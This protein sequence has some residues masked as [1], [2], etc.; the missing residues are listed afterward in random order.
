VEAGAE[1][2]VGLLAL[3]PGPDIGV[4]GAAV[5][6]NLSQARAAAVLAGSVEAGLV[7]VRDGRY[8][9]PGPGQVV[10]DAVRRR[11]LGRLFGWYRDLANAADRVLRPAE[12]PNFASRQPK[13]AFPDQ[14]AALGWLDAEAAN[15][16][17]AVRAAA[18]EHPVLSWQIAAAMYGWLTRREQRAE[19]I[20]LYT[21]AAG[22]AARCGD[23]AGEA[24]ITGRLGIAYGLLG[25]ATEAIAAFHRA[26]EI[27][28]AG[29][30]LLGAATGLLNIGAMQVATG[31]P[32]D[33]IASLSRA[34][35]LGGGLP[36]TTHFQALVHSNLA[37]A[38]HIA[39][40]YA[41]A[42]HHYETALRHSEAGCAD[43]DIAQV[44]LGLA[45]LCSTLG[46]DDRA[47]AYAHRGLRLADRADDDLMRAQSHEALGRIA[48][49]TGGTRSARVHLRAALS[50]YTT[51]GYL[52]AGAVREQLAGLEAV[53]TESAAGAPAIATPA[54]DP[55]TP[56]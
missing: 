27:R 38:H 44:L 14:A 9:V 42:M 4:E 8:A 50:T 15:L 46:R 2:A 37:E 5:L 32:A 55:G 31:A 47:R 33:A 43:R 17:A 34:K 40:R 3:A 41:P 29:G 56:A 16:G 19:W 6:L 12:R 13:R 52:G 48:A 35:E 22:A 26:Y 7:G 28:L 23:T 49:A 30:D 36:D 39:G 1:R 21:V 53:P 25:Q 20:A 24:L 45:M 54:A 18:A 11:A 51:M 10:P